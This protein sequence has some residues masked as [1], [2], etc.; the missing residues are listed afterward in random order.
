MDVLRF[1]ESEGFAAVKL[2][3]Y[4]S[5]LPEKDNWHQR[6]QNELIAYHDTFY[7]NLYSYDFM[8]PMDTD[9]FIIPLRPEDKNW[10]DLLN[11]TAWKALNA[12]K[13]ADS[14][15]VENH[16]FLLKTPLKNFTYIAGIP[17]NLYFLS[18]IFRA[19]N[20]TPHNGNAK[21]F[22]RM[23]R[24]LTIHN[25]FPFSCVDNSNKNWCETFKVARE[26]GQLS[27]YRHECQTD[28]CKN[29]ILSPV[30][31][32]TLYKYKDQIVNGVK[33]VVDGL[34]LFTGGKL[35]INLG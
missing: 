19:A 30:A 22:L 14:Y 10:A 5:S 15:Q 27:H 6:M 32:V 29:S 18:N 11:R 20:F 3:K 9:E 23:D 34:K 21:T 31:D 4:P 8:L 25:H 2:I 1:Y 28:E 13:F 16:Y 7:E 12:K 26:D 33:R 24:V 35:N 17:K